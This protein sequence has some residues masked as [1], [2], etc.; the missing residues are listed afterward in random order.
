MHQYGNGVYALPPR[1]RLPL[2][3]QSPFTRV[4]SLLCTTGSPVWASTVSC[5]KTALGAVC[6]DSA[7][8]GVEGWAVAPHGEQLNLM[9]FE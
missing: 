7:L 2:V 1:V 5:L 9:H 3:W 4:P 8:I 6:I